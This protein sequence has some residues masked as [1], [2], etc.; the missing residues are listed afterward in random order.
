MA[1]KHQFYPEFRE[2]RSR[3]FWHEKREVQNV[4]EIEKTRREQTLSS[5]TKKVS[6][7]SRPIFFNVPS[8][9]LK[10]ILCYI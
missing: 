7:A 2:T 9:P 3:F 1:K 6:P 10:E 4:R 5:T 8:P